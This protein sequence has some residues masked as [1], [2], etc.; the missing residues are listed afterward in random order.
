MSTKISL[1]IQTTSILWIF[2]CLLILFSLI[3]IFSPNIRQNI[4]SRGF[5]NNF[6]IKIRSLV[7]VVALLGSLYFSEIAKFQPCDLCWIQRIFIFPLAIWSIVALFNIKE[8]FSKIF[9]IFPAI[10]VPISI[11]HVLIEKYPSLHGVTSCDLKVPCTVPAF[12]YWGFL[13]M[14]CM[15][16]TV[17]VSSIVLT[18]LSNRLKN[19]VK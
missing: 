3:A 13:T 5:D 19:G 11:Y 4:Y 12:E 8:S 17:L 18:I 14:A 6:F 7:L 1:A 9:I 16:L 2:C 15:A 10:C